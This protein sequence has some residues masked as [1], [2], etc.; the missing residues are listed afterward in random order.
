MLQ[1]WYQKT[2]QSLVNT[3]VL[4]SWHIGGSEPHVQ[5]FLNFAKSCI[6]SCWSKF[7]NKKTFHLAKYK[8]LKRKLR[9]FLAGHSVTM[10]TYCVTKI[11]LTCSP[12]MQHQLIKTGYN[13]ASKCTSWNE[14]ET[15]LSHLEADYPLF[16]WLKPW[17]NGFASKRKWKTWIYLRLRLAKAC[18]HLRWF[19]MTCAHFGRDQICTQ[20]KAAFLPFGHPTQVD[21]SW[22]TAINLL[23]VNELQDMSAL[24]YF[25]CDSRVLVRKLTSAFGHPMQV[26]T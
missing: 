23:L 8:R 2:A 20:D 15:V 1:S 5:N 26:S 18:V 19:A 9:V 25:F 11:I 14:L 10:V 21:A 4:F 17:P 7:Y 24:K 13:D 6:L 12:V 16:H 3:L 22:V